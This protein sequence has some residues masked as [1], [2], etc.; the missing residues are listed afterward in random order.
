[1]SP[2]SRLPACVLRS[3]IPL[4]FVCAY[5][6]CCPSSRYEN[7]RNPDVVRQCLVSRANVTWTNEADGGNTCLHRAS[8]VGVRALPTHNAQSHPSSLTSW[9]ITISIAGVV[10]ARD[11]SR[12]C[13]LR[14]CGSSG[15]VLPTAI[16]RVLWLACPPTHL[17]LPFPYHHQHAQPTATVTL[18]LLEANADIHAVNDKGLTPL[19]CACQKGWLPVAQALVAAKVRRP[20]ALLLSAVVSCIAWS[21]S[22][23]LRAGSSVDVNACGIGVSECGRSLPVVSVGRQL[24]ERAGVANA[25]SVVQ[26]Y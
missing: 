20:P 6:V 21:P 24:G 14:L 11:Y 7:I 1:V 26:L 8:V 16:V 22:M 2:P 9:G 19:H 10:A 4:L 25:E 13:L 23:G 3:T 17:P 15:V 12:F 5:H 18:M